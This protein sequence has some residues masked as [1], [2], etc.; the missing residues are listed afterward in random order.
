MKKIIAFAIFSFPHWSKTETFMPYRESLFRKVCDCVF[1]YVRNVLKR[2][3]LGATFS[4]QMKQ[5]T[6]E[7]TRGGGFCSLFSNKMRPL[8]SPH[9]PNEG[10]WKELKSSL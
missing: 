6:S 4:S 8:P 5:D 3:S 1:E 2:V 10:N 9:P 7:E